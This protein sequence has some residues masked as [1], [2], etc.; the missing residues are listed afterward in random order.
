MIAIVDY[1]AGNLRSVE[2]ALQRLGAGYQVTSDPGTILRASHVIMPGVGEASSAMANLEL[3]GLVP[4]IRSLRQPVLG[5]CIGLQLMCTFSEEGPVNCLGIFDAPVRRF[6]SAPG[7]KIPHMGWNTVEGLEGPL[8]K[9]V[10]DNSF[11]Y[12]VHSYR[13]DLAG[14][15]TIARTRYSEGPFSAALQ[16]DNFFGTQFHPEKSGQVGARIIKN[17]IEL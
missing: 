14:S 13:P 12:Y 8:F 6:E 4:V 7:V 16:K 3:T 10:P 17:F 2:N 9:G 5:I 11:V 15:Q 1:R